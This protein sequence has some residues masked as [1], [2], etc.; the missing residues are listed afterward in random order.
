MPNK[1]NQKDVLAHQRITDH[2]KLCR[3]M[4]KQTQSQINK[5]HNKIDRLEKILLTSTGFLLS[6]MVGI[7]VAL[8]FRFL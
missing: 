3:I 8:L 6:S 2:E 7:I 4:Q 1:P 5:L